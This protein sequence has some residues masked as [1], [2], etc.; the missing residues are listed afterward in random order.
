MSQVQACAFRD[1][2]F[3]LFYAFQTCD[4]FI[5]VFLLIGG[6]TQKVQVVAK[7]VFFLFLTCFFISGQVVNS[8]LVISFGVIEFTQ[9]AVYFSIVLVIGIPF[10]QVFCPLIDFLVV[11][12]CV[13]DLDNVVRH[14]LVVLRCLFYLKERRQGF[15][16]FALRIQTVGVVVF[17]LY[18]VRILGVFQGTETC[19]SLLDIASLDIIV[20]AIEIV[21]RLF[22][23]WQI[24]DHHFR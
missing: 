10:Q 20:A 2:V 24:F 15:L 11:A 12:L 5:I 14:Y 21:H 23:A 19:G 6:Y 7:H 18:R 9:N 3:F 13:I 8:L 16:V 4:G 22:I 17:A 1:G